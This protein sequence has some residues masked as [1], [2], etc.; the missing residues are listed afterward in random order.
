[1]TRKRSQR[2]ARR[3]LAGGKAAGAVFA[4]LMAASPA[5]AVDEGDFVID[6]AGDLA[7]L[8]AAAPDSPLHAAA[9]HMCQGYLLGVHHFHTALAIELG[10][11]IYCPPPPE[12]T[13]TRNE[14]TAAFVAWVAANPQVRGGEALDGLLAWAAAAYPCP[15]SM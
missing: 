13:Q 15:T 2:E 3:R 7:D 6:T 4:A 9:V 8:C 1:M 14:V 10:N 5:A 12:Q 11:D